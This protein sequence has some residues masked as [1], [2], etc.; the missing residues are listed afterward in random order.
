MCSRK[1]I[2]L[3][4]D[5][6]LTLVFGRAAAVPVSHFPYQ[7]AMFAASSGHLAVQLV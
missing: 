5:D 4:V 6:S 1:M 2:I 7:Q 3:L